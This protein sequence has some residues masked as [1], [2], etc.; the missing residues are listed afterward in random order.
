MVPW[1]L[2]KQVGKG[3]NSL[4][5]TPSRSRIFQDYFEGYHASMRY[6]KPK[7]LVGAARRDRPT[8]KG[9]FYNTV[10]ALPQ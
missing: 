9:R 4:F 2:E 6:P 1:G 10:T 5:D 8:K 7:P 3:L